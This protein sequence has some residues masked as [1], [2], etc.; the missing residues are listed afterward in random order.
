M[1]TTMYKIIFTFIILG[2]MGETYGQRNWVG[3][4]F[5][6]KG[7]ASSLATNGQF[8]EGSRT[9]SLIYP[10]IFY[11]H[12]V[13][14]RRGYNLGINPLASLKTKFQSTDGLIKNENTYNG[15]TA[16]LG[17]FGCIASDYLSKFQIQLANNFTIGF[18]GDESFFMMDFGLSGQF[19]VTKNIKIAVD[20]FPLSFYVGGYGSAK[21]NGGIKILYAP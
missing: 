12:Y 8:A 9:G 20:A 7:M 1:K 4:G 10:G 19:K 18:L 15:I 6:V 17:L 3:L 16:S 11:S 21:F 14:A 13:S 2:W 5:G